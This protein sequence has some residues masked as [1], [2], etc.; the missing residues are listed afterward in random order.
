MS[1]FVKFAISLILLMFLELF[2]FSTIVISIIALYSN[3][4]TKCQKGI[5]YSIIGILIFI[6]ITMIKRYYY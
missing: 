6:V 3:I 4:K 2:R 1:D 5:I